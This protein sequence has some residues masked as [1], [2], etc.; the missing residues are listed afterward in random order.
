VRS[1]S[2]LLVAAAIVALSGRPA[3][4]FNWTYF[5][6]TKE[7]I[8]TT[9]EEEGDTDFRATCKAGGKADIGI[10]AAEGIGKGE[11][12]TVSVTLATGMT[13]LKIDGKSAQS[14]NFQMTAGVELQTTVDSA[15]P[16]FALLGA[17]GSITVSGPIKATW[18]AKDRAAAT[19]TFAKACFGK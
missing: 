16:I 3:L 4:A 11:G 14:P 13:S 17:T 7:L 8:G 9:G 12:E 10:G 19:M 6:E 15:H 2:P 5:A 1:S 18:P